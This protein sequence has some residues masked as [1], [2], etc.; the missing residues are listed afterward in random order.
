MR[1][2]NVAFFD[3]NQYCTPANKYG[4]LD[5]NNDYR[6]LVPLNEEATSK[7][8][9]CELYDEDGGINCNM[10]CFSFREDTFYYMEEYI[11]LVLNSKLGISINM[12]EEEYIDTNQLDDAIDIMESILNNTDDNAVIDF[13]QKLLEMMRM[14]K[15][16]GTIV[17]FCF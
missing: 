11:F 12:Y 13:S 15:E 9:S 4:Y 1:D 10:I 2:D 7:L 17:G 14:A 6:I 8:W 5:L 16:K 3:I